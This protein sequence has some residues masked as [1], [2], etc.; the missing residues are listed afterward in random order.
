MT[1]KKMNLSLSTLLGLC[2]LLMTSCGW[3]DDGYFN[4]EKGEGDI[5]SAS[6]EF[7]NFSGIELDIAADV[8]LSQGDNFEVIAEGQEN[9]IDLLEFD[10][11]NNNLRIDFENCARDYNPL[12]FFITMP[13]LEYVSIDGSGEVRGETFF[14]VNDL[15]L[16]ISGSG[17]IDLGIENA[18][19]VDAKISGSGK[20]FLEGDADKLDFRVSGSGDL[21]AFKLE[22]RKA[23]INISGSGNVEVFATNDLDIR[24]SGSGDV[25]YIGNPS[26]SVD[27]SG[28][29][30]VVDAN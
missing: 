30:E 25:F 4:C 9:I 2:L 16:D 20:L 13:D 28:S 17:D 14:V 27:I 15:E 12:T 3:D 23:D 8:V 26:I 21:C 7:D 19:D 5:I 18:D 24:I 6:F 11:R 10:I 22:A 29:G 1:T